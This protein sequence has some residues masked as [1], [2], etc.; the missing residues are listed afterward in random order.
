MNERTQ[1]FALTDADRKRRARSQEKL[2]QL[3]EKRR[4]EIEAQI[5][6][7][8]DLRRKRWSQYSV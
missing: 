1:S 6:E 8:E 4:E 3:R 7:E 2:A 5:R